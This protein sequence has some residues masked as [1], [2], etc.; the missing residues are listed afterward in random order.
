MFWYF[1]YKPQTILT[2]SCMYN[3]KLPRCYSNPNLIQSHV[4]ILSRAPVLRDPYVYN[5][6][7][8][9][10]FSWLNQTNKC[11]LGGNTSGNIF[12]SFDTLLENVLM[13]Y[14]EL[15]ERFQTNSASNLS[16]DSDGSDT[17]SCSSSYSEYSE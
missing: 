4:D 11:L 6:A 12:K 2:T 3:R 14:R 5:M 9:S 1:Y 15:G 17:Q 16:E 13:A 10:R 8:S 7:S